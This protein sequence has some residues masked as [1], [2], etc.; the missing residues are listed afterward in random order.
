MENLD[1]DIIS[2]SD[3]FE[4]NSTSQQS[5]IENNIL[6]QNTTNLQIESV[7]TPEDIEFNKTIENIFHNIHET[8]KPDINI[9]VPDDYP[10]QLEVY[11][12]DNT[13]Q[14][15]LKLTNTG[16]ID[17]FTSSGYGLGLRN[18]YKSVSIDIPNEYDKH[19]DVEYDDTQCNNY[20]CCLFGGLFIIYPLNL[21]L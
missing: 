19:N 7:S 8:V 11:S 5:H 9:E 3:I 16:D 10:N 18:N 20:L 14:K 2:Y 15:D 6:E 4:I 1:F 17:I 12:A 13:N 21:L